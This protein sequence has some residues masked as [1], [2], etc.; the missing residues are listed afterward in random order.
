MERSIK[1]KQ[2]QV[3][4]YNVIANAAGTAL[5]GLDANQVTMTDT[6]TGD[7]L[8]TLPEALQN[9]VVQVTVA[10]ADAVP[11]VGTITSTTVQVL[12]FDATDGTTAKDAICHITITGSKISDQY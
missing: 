7:K 3:V 6:G 5:T 12:S 8:I 2:R 1:S 9:A 4:Q 10:T 11:Q